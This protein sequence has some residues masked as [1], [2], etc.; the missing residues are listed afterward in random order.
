MRRTK[1][2][3]VA[4]RPGAQ[5][6]SVDEARAKADAL[7]AKIA[8]GADFA[9][10]AK[11]ESDDTAS[12]EK[13]GDIGFVVRGSSDANFEEA[14]Y[15]LPVG[16]LSDVIKT[17]FGFHILR[18]EERR[19]LPL[20]SSKAMVGNALANEAMDSIVRKGYKLNEAYFGK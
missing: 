5:E 11:A 15:A 12:R 8:G 16:K 17:E 3:P 4:L 14:A 19:P 13:G 2:S 20:E 18:V 7:R 10:V 6:W 9:A 1:G